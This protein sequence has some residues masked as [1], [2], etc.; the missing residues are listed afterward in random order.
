M[1]AGRRRALSSERNP[2]R[3]LT[4][5]E[6]E[7]LQARISGMSPVH[8]DHFRALADHPGGRARLRDACYVAPLSP[9]EV[10][11]AARR[12]AHVELAGVP[13]DLVAI[14]RGMASSERGRAA[15]RRRGIRP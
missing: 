1:T 8:A 7:N 12:G 13:V 15:L 10:A 5:K 11:A 3:P 9:S 14:V 2:G 6:W 4:R